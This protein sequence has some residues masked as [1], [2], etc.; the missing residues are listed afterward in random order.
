MLDLKYKTK[1]IF[2][3]LG[4]KCNLKCSYCIEQSQNMMLPDCREINE[5]VIKFIR[6]QKPEQI[7]FYG[8]EALLYMDKIKKI[9]SEL[10]DLKIEYTVFTNGKLLT[11]E[12]VDYFNENDVFVHVSWDGSQSMLTR[13]YDALKDKEDLLANINILNIQPVLS[14]KVDLLEFLKDV[15]PFFEKYYAIHQYHTNIT[16]GIIYD[17][18]GKL[19][20]LTHFDFDEF[21]KR[22]E[23]FV[24]EA[25][26]AM[27]KKD[28]T[29]Y[30]LLLIKAYRFVIFDVEA[31]EKIRGADC[32]NGSTT[33]NLDLYGNLYQCHNTGKLI[34]NIHDLYNRK[35]DENDELANEHLKAE[36]KDCEVLSFC[37]GGCPSMDKTMRDDTNYCKIRKIFYGVFLDSVRKMGVKI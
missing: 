25:V 33:I 14:S 4:T 10:K 35:L 31:R 22:T 12:M 8:G 28:K 21:K 32:K 16:F 24:K 2:I 3:M 7:R 34:G 5:D 19:K 36:C 17:L 26:K 29:F 15:T 1:I 13:G 11:Q 30:D 23:L 9:I 37:K 6:K 20:D 27:G 18:S